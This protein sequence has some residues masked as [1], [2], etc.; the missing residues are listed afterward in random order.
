MP[1]KKQQESDRVVYYLQPSFF[2]F[3]TMLLTK[4]VKH[5][6]RGIQWIM[7]ERLEDPDF[8]SEIC[9]LA[10]GQSDT[11]ARLEKL[12]KEAA[13]MGPKINELTTEEIRVNCNTDLVVTINDREVEQ[14]KSF[15]NLGST[16]TVDDGVLEDVTNPGPSW[17]CI[18]FGGIKISQL[19]LKVGCLIQLLSQA[20]CRDVKCGKQLNGF[21]IHYRYLQT[22]KYDAF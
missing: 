22:N 21:V 6:K 11:R 1:W 18:H 7:M 15:M 8:A 2:F 20:C 13:K 14:V 5:R 10:Q 9:L 12:E 4:V 16:V 3:W 17:C 19:E